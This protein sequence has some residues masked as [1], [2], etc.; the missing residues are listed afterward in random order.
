MTQVAC[1]LFVLGAAALSAAA[2]PTASLL[3]PIASCNALLATLW[4]ALLARGAGARFLTLTLVVFV[5]ICAIVALVGGWPYPVL[6]AAILALYGWD[7]ALTARAIAPFPAKDR[8]RLIRHQV[9]KALSLGGGGFALAACGLEWQV[10]LGF[11]AT[12]GLGLASLLVLGI[13][14][15]TLIGRR[16]K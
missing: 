11:S 4:I 9:L 10:R 12:L 16:S 7:T 1:A 15:R 2:L 14:F 5:A 13:G 6:A 8:R 3:F